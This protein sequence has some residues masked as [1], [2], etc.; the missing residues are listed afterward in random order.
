VA[1][2]G[3]VAVQIQLCWFCCCRDPLARVRLPSGRVQIPWIRES[4]RPPHFS[5]FLGLFL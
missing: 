2:W 1:E 5:T 3:T 4:R